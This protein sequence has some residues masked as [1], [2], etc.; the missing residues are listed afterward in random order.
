M[1]FDIIAFFLG[2]VI[3]GQVSTPPERTPVS[4][5]IDKSSPLTGITT[6][7][8]LT[9]QELV[10]NI[11]ATGAC[12]T[13]TNVQA[14]GNDQGIGY[15]SNGGD[16]IGLQEG[17]I[18]S[19]GKISNAH[20]PNQ[21]S[22]ISWNFNDGSGD[23]DL[24]SVATEEVRDAA[25][26]VFDFIPLDSVIIFRYVFASEEYCE[27]VGSDFNDVF[28]FFISGPGIS[29]PYSYGAENVA[30]IPGSNSL[31]S[32]NTV[33]HNLN[34]AYYI[35]NERQEDAIECEIPFNPS[36]PDNIEFDGFTKVL[37]ATLELIPCET[38]RIRMVIG[39]VKDNVFDSAVFLEAGSFNLGT[40]IEVSAAGGGAGSPQIVSEGCEAFYLFERESGAP[41]DNPITVNYHLSGESTALPGADFVDFP[42]TVTIPAGETSV[43]LPV[44]TLNDEDTEPGES[45]TVVLDVPCQCYADSATLTIVEPIPVL[46]DLPDIYVC[47]GATV[48]HSPV[49]SGGNPPYTYLWSTGQTLEN[50]D[51]TG[52]EDALYAVTVFDACGHWTV[53]S[54]TIL[55]TAPPIANLTGEATV[56]EGDTAYFQVTFSGIPPFEFTYAIN[57]QNQNPVSGISTGSYSIPGFEEGLYEVIFLE[58]QVCAGSVS[59]TAQLEVMEMDASL[60]VLD[61]S[62]FGF[63]D[64]A[65]AI[66]VT[67]ANPPF[68]YHWSENLGNESEVDSL[69]AGNYS[70][71]VTDA[72]QCEEIH[73]IAVTEPSE[74]EAIEFDCDM[75]FSGKLDL[76]A[77]G[78]TPPYLY[79]ANDAPFQGAMIFDSLIAGDTYIMS[80]QDANGCLLEQEFIMPVLYD[81]MFF[82][83]EEIEALKGEQHEL[84]LELNFPESLLA[85]VIWAPAD[86]LS[87]TDCLN[88]I[89]TAIDGGIYFVQV[90]DV[91]GCK[92]F[93]GVDISIKE[94]IDYYVPTIFSPDGDQVNDYF[95]PFFNENHVKE[96]LL[97][98][99]F[100]RWGGMMHEV[101]NI[102]PNNE[103]LGW[104]GTLGGRPLNSGVYVYLVKVRLRDGREMVITGDIVLMR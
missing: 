60:S 76:A 7:D 80:I 64:G 55:I 25:G 85:S 21:A 43:M 79:R 87:C 57:G 77:V 86:N 53:D 93:A 39:D 40:R 35:G 9:V 22:D 15:F 68:N 104:D 5:G 37:T 33:N 54:C 51:I 62:C 6:D 11:F 42:L 8:A 45:I 27:F 3:L 69:G 46:V 74:L 36:Q 30:R 50:I 66:M 31:V 103:R 63:S 82:L 38:Y 97:F 102:L 71:T 91:F 101:K 47:E 13:I 41:L 92:T 23:P 14:I 1:K 49:V 98:Q 29:G 95:M 26:I 81:P 94:K 84:M 83:P 99:V 67:G 17:I 24:D 65:A 32:V 59:G 20:G 4:A 19:T 73:E 100:N 90:T 10:T 52:V 28:G 48:P 96:V 18:L 72:Q 12:E 34:S 70:V 61:V 44:A 88:P 58:D 89:H 78:G 56:C 2:F 75:L 16:V